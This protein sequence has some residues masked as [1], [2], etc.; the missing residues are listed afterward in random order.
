MKELKDHIEQIKQLCNAYHV[1][2]LFAFGSVVSNNLKSTS[3][4]DL[5]VDIDSKDPIDY[6]DNYFALK[7]QLEQIL[8]R[9]VD[10]LED[11][12]LK[13]PFL[14]KQIDNTKVLVY[15]R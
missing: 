15:G 3:D 7:F 9:P 2:S 4:I 14:K 11:K 10:L 12:A 6:T 5:I 1:R 8:N 13:N